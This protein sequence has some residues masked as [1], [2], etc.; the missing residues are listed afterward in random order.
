MSDDLRRTSG[1]LGIGCN[2]D[3]RRGQGG[4]KDVHDAQRKIT[5][6][7]ASGA[8]GGTVALHRLHVRRHFRAHDRG[9][10]ASGHVSEGPR[11]AA[12]DDGGRVACG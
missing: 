4:S 2:A 1:K 12:A 6:T 3:A 7:E 9:Y 10:P 8:G 5:P 11:I